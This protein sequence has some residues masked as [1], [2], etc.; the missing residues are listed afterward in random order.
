MLLGFLFLEKL[1]RTT[2]C[3]VPMVVVKLLLIRCAAAIV[4]TFS[5][6]VARQTHF[7]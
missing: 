2:L 4:K 5:W 7:D 1:L 6:V 3:N